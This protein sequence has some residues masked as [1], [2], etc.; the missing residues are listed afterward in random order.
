MNLLQRVRIMAFSSVC[1][2]GTSLLRSLRTA[3]PGI[4]A[5]KRSLEHV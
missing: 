4:V 5:I 3:V 2:E 1:Y